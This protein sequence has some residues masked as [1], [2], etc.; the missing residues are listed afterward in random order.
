MNKEELH[1]FVDSLTIEEVLSVSISY[2]SEP[3]KKPAPYNDELPRDIKCVSYG[4]DINSH[5][6]DIRRRMEEM[7][8]RIDSNICR[9]IEEKL[10]EREMRK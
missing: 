7:G 1:K 10:N 2:F 5:L 8:Y 6:D 4:K 9:I 3:Y